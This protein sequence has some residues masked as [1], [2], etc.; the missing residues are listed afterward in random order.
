[1]DTQAGVTGAELLGAVAAAE[2]E[3]AAAPGEAPLGEWAAVRVRPD[4]AA[5]LTTQALLASS[6]EAQAALQARRTL[7][8]GLRAQGKRSGAAGQLR[9][10]AG[11]AAGAPQSGFRVRAHC[12]RTGAAGQLWGVGGGAAGAPHGLTCR[13]HPFFA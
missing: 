4:A 3:R 11:R 9:G 6:E 8:S 1:M 13:L 10:G 2:R 5:P 12:D 7:S